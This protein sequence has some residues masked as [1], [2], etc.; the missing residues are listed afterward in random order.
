MKILSTWLLKHHM[1]II[2]VNLKV[3][4]ERTYAM[5]IVNPVE[6]N[7]FMVVGWKVLKTLPKWIHNTN[8][9]VVYIIEKGAN[10]VDVVEPYEVGKAGGKDEEDEEENEE[11]DEEGKQDEDEDIEEEEEELK[12]VDEEDGKRGQRRRRS[13]GSGGRR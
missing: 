2:M 11:D 9:W 12:V 5:K 10:E 3:K 4:N 1:A 8:S 7:N 6:Q 13:S